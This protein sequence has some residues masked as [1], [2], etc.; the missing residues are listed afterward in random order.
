MKKVN[1]FILAFLCLNLLYQIF[2]TISVYWLSLFST[3]VPSLIRDGLRCIF[4]LVIILTNLNKLNS[5]IKKR[6]KSWL[7]FIGLLIF[8]VLLSYLFLDKWLSDIFI[9]IK[10]GFWRIFILISASFI[11][12]TLNLQNIKQ[13]KITYYLLWVVI[14][15]FIRQIL[16]LLKPERFAS[17]W[18]SLKLDDF[19]FWA[20]PPIYYLTWFEGT[21][22]RQWLFSWPNNYGY[23]LVAFF[24][25]LLAQLKKT[26]KLSILTTVLR[27]L[28]MILTLSRAVFIWWLIIL[29]LTYR[30][31]IKRYKK[32]IIWWW[33]WFF[34]LLI[35][36]S[37]RKRDST[38]GHLSS[39]IS[40]IQTVIQHP[41]GLWLGSSWPAIHHWGSILPENYYFQILLDIWFI[42]FGLFFL[43]IMNIARN[44]KANYQNQLHYFIIGFIALLVIGLFLHVFEDSMV[45][46]LFFIPFGLILGH[47]SSSK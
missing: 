3:S 13:S 4:F 33:I 2:S 46:Y 19:A 41:M 24:P 12:Y 15:G 37:L 7:C 1:R 18:Y 6:W 31:Q 35:I 27:V 22:R 28:A 23:F 47:L 38:I 25:I 39:F 43:V 10:Y 14:I 32:L 30:T 45:N 26:N 42:G 29:I 40:A 16:K 11:W 20:N 34:C 21:L 36:I 17:M 8:S 9:G 5:Y 44:I